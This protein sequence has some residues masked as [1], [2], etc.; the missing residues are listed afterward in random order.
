MHVFA[1]IDV[2][3]AIHVDAMNRLKKMEKERQMFDK[4]RQEKYVY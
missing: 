1:L 4:N 3:H 2:R